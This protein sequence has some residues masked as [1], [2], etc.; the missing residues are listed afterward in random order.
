MRISR[1]YWK[2]AISSKEIGKRAGSVQSLR[3]QGGGRGLSLPITREPV[4][5]RSN[6]IRC[7]SRLVSSLDKIV[8]ETSD[9][10]LSQFCGHKEPA[11]YG[12][13]KFR[14]AFACE[15]I[16]GI[17]PHRREGNLYHAPHVHDVEGSIDE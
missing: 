17:G 9:Q 7:P 11:D 13:L 1:C 6:R 14:I 2:W 4:V 12:P 16:V 8:C 3:S 10:L 15:K 5:L